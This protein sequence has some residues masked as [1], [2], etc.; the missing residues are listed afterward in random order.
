[1]SAALKFIETHSITTPGD[2]LDFD[3]TE[4]ISVSDAIYATKLAVLE[5]AYYL[6]E[7]EPGIMRAMVDDKVREL[8]RQKVSL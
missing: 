3:T 4:D 6:R 8:Q 1:M 5:F 2:G 7:L